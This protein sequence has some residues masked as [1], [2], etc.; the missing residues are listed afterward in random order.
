MLMAS[1]SEMRSR[2]DFFFE[3]KIKTSFGLL[4]MAL[5]PSPGG[6]LLFIREAVLIVSLQVML[7]YQTS[8][9]MINVN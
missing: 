4:K 3:G 8:D 9:M 6:K 2:E 5:S 7:Q 1:Q